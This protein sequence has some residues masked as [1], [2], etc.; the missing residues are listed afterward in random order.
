MD[1]WG[2][3]QTTIAPLVKKLFDEG[4][5]VTGPLSADGFFA[6]YGKKGF[7]PEVHGVLAMYHDQGLG[8]YKILSQGAGVNITSGLT[9]VRTSPDHGTADD[10]AGK[11]IANADAMYEAIQTGLRLLEV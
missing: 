4:M 9:V 6:R 7:E 11:N 3:E 2:E 5:D 8:P 10:I 1:Y